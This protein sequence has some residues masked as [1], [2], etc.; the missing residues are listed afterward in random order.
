MKTNKAYLIIELVLIF[1]GIPLIYYFEWVNIP[2]IPSLVLLTT[3]C[4]VVLLKD[5]SFDRTK[6]WNYRSAREFILK[7]VIRFGLAAIFLAI[8]TFVFF[9]EKFLLFPKTRPLIWVIVMIFY[10]IL[11][12]F[13]QELIYRVFLFHRYESLFKNDSVKII[14]SAVAFS[15]LHIMY[16]NFYALFLSLLGGFLFAMTYF[17]SKSLFLVGLEHA[18]YGCFVFTIGLGQFFYEGY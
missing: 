10:P 8:F 13:P 12:A 6:L 7:M 2:K 18:L 17:K 5:Q 3:F 4:M 15:F 16:D 9:P 1:L 11:S 14:A